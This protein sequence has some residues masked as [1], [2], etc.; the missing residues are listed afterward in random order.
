MAY[1]LKYSQ[2]ITKGGATIQIRVYVKDYSGASYGMAHLTGASLQIIGGQSDPLTPIIKTALSWSLAD[3]WDE[4]TTQA[5][6]TECVNAQG[7]K[8]GR[9]EEF[10]TPDATKFRVELWAAQTAAAT[11]ACI[12]TGYITPDS[13]SENMIYRGSIT[14]TARD[15]LG[16]LQEKE[17]NLTGRVSILDIVQGALSA[18]A[19]PMALSYTAGH[20]LVNSNGQSI[21]A[22]TIAAST[23]S[24]DNWQTALEDTL[25]S[26][27]LVLRYNGANGL[28]LA[29]LRYVREDTL[30]GTHTIEFT[31]R[32]G[33]RE[34]VPA[35][36][37]ITETFDLEIVNIPAS[38][39][40][41]SQYAA[42]GGNLTQVV[43][44]HTPSGTFT[45]TNYI[46]G[47]TLTESGGEGWSGGLA[48]PA[49]GTPIEGIP[50]RKMWFPTDVTDAVQAVW[51]N[52]RLRG[53]YA[54]KIEQDGPVAWWT[55]SAP[56]THLAPFY[57]NNTIKEIEIQ[58]V[59]VV[60][61]TTK[62][63][64]PS[65]SWDT[66]ENTI[67]YAIGSEINVPDCGAVGAKIIIKKV[68]TECTYPASRALFVALNLS[69]QPATEGSTIISEYKT[70]TEYD[71]KNN[72][73]IT[74]SPKVGSAT[75][76]GCVDFY[77][78]VLAYG[79]AIAPNE[80]N[81]PGQSSYYPLAVMIQAQVLCYH[82][83]AASVFTGTAH[84]KTLAGAFALPGC[85]YEYY[86]RGCIPLSATF[87]FV[88]GFVG[89][90]N[91]REVYSWADVWGASFEPQYTQKSGSGK[92]S[93]S[94]TGT[95]G[96]AVSPGGGGGGGSLP[97]GVNYFELD[98]TLVR[99]K[100]Q[101]DYL[102][103][104][105]G[106]IFEAVSESDA[107]L[108]VKEI[109]VGSSTQRVLYS[110]LPLITEGDQIVSSG[111]PGGGGGGGATYMRDLEDV[112][113]TNLSNG[114]MLAWDASLRSGQG[115][116]K[117]VPAPTGTIT[118]VALASGTNN[119]TLKLTVNGVATDNIAVTGWSSKADASALGN[120]LPLS[121]GSANPLTANLYL[122]Y[123]TTS[124][125]QW[126]VFQASDGTDTRYI[127]LRKPLSYYG[128]T[129]YDG[130][131]NLIYHS[132]NF[133]VTLNGTSTTSASFYAP[134]TAG[135]TGQI[136]KATTSGA[137]VWTSSAL[138]GTNKPIYLDSSGILTAGVACLPLTAGDTVPLTGRL[139][140]K[141][142]Y[143]AWTASD[144]SFNGSIEVESDHIFKFND[145]T[146]T[147]YV[148]HTGNFVAGTNYVSITGDET[149]TGQK[150]ISSAGVGLI[151]NRTQSN[152]TAWVQFQKSGTTVG[153]IGVDDSS[154]PKFYDGV[155]AER[156]IWHSGNSN[157]TSTSWI[158]STIS[159]I[160]NG[161][162]IS[163][164]STSITSS[165]D[166]GGAAAEIGVYHE[167]GAYL[168][169][170]TSGKTYLQVGR[171]T[172]TT[173]YDL[174]LQ[175]Y[176][177]NVGIGT[178][179]P[180]EKLH[181]HQAG[182]ATL[183][184]TG[185][186]DSGN[187]GTILFQSNVS[188]NYNGFKIAS[189]IDVNVGR[190]KLIFYSS[191]NGTSPYA[192][193]WNVAMCINRL[194][195]VGVGTASPGAKLDVAGTSSSVLSIPYA[196]DGLMIHTTG[197]AENNY[198]LF[199]SVAET[200]LGTV[201]TPALV[202]RATGNVG[203]GTSSP[204]H[205][206]HVS[207]NSYINGDVSTTGSINILN[208]GSGIYNRCQISS[209]SS[210]FFIEAPMTTDSRTGTKVPL[211]FGWR[212]GTYPLVI[213]ANT[214][215]GIGTGTPSYKLDV[216]GT[217]H[218]TSLLIDQ[219]GG[220]YCGP[221]S[222]QIRKIYGCDSDGG[223]YTRMASYAMLPD[224]DTNDCWQVRPWNG[225]FANAYITVYHGG[226]VNIGTTTNG[227][228]P[229]YV[230]GSIC[231]T[232]DQVVSSDLTLKTN[233]QDV[234]YGVKDIAKCR[235]V[236]FD[237]KDGRGHSAG[238]IAQDWKPL[239]PELVHGEEGSMT[240]A[241]GQIAL[242]NTI[243]E[244]REIEVLKK[245]V[246]ELEDEVKRLRS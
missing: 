70:T 220:I 112:S 54:V 81:W 149:I 181:I 122:K 80:W 163:A 35:L 153:Y 131:Y 2:Y 83:A 246:A 117:N 32:S 140:I 175:P 119:G 13:W 93:T 210:S 34:L 156:T 39:P 85:A 97:G 65:G 194:G 168:W 218:T 213:A 136:L 106:L 61:G 172:G 200:T 165:S 152:S 216:N 72:V 69:V 187:A 243:I 221:S 133:S 233:L 58:V 203:I 125:D 24:G 162:S 234:T 10:Y 189:E 12:W 73:T 193:S 71:Q 134:T 91:I 132:G 77:E 26:L 240:V 49:P 20:F 164:Y 236:T 201:A 196:G 206:L 155:T 230:S 174:G 3:C 90:M 160:S 102:G 126:I 242:V 28:V 50:E 173:R 143:L 14:I 215:V 8:C 79:D 88:S 59:A 214:N 154:T 202:V 166:M 118:S 179:S 228:Y 96:S 104:R 38:D 48:T 144:N 182:G 199:C 123:G 139:Y 217:T 45:N 177:G 64:S 227:G 191:N 82:A 99:L 76:S 100:G 169:A 198:A 114:Q 223:T 15:M 170:S 5:D 105:K 36:R 116:W 124:S 56:N 178:D 67:H 145:G 120:Y 148:Y 92:G 128:L 150:I 53:S 111:T 30:S 241:Y 84:D 6:G 231:S 235:A 226:Y 52:P 137:P 204:A 66:A 237:W 208:P 185:N 21:L 37:E 142:N 130:K 113:L 211:M 75:L 184:I 127:G 245:R 101:Y 29:P 115:A 55:G 11:P 158:C 209:S 129:Y 95:G 183:K 74:R 68:I 33:L 219:S 159:A 94:A 225:A 180:T 157:N 135:T 42:T 186:S 62:Y 51:N 22:H 9:W 167:Y 43:V 19:A 60:N 87:D 18:C 244:A 197:N 224:N 25:E 98:D 103:P 109:T 161:S 146:A 121:A 23:F 229:L 17:F 57:G 107:D 40:D 47:Y 86:Q 147:R 151:L 239:I 141:N 46:P 44:A 41:E 222:S 195:N 4:G 16:A 31:G 108:Y 7:E 190:Q 188:N 171:Y 192:P 63:L 238:S 1:G 89:Q 27:G 232:G 176:G 212:G 110:P 78:N 205:K 138:G 207:G